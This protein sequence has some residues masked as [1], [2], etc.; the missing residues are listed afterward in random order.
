[1]NEWKHHHSFEWFMWAYLQAVS[2]V[3]SI[4]TALWLYFHSVWTHSQLSL[5]F[6]FWLNWN[7][8]LW[9]ATFHSCVLWSVFSRAGGIPLPSFSSSVS[10]DLDSESV[11][12]VFF[13]W[14]Y[15]RYC[16]PFS[17]IYSSITLCIVTLNLRS[18]IIS[19]SIYLILY[20]FL[21]TLSLQWGYPS[22]LLVCLIGWFW[23]YYS[24][25]CLL[26]LEELSG[27]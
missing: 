26:L 15:I 21:F 13:W 3:L 12:L 2:L 20:K 5:L 19:Y 8:L 16:L 27:K 23:F 24:H 11:S 17:G 22:G 7:S 9:F 1:M 4:F 10:L 25:V 18:N 6:H 14:C